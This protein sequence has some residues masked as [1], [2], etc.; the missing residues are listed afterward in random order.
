MHAN[1]PDRFADC[2]SL[3][4]LFRSI[5]QG[6]PNAVAVVDGPVKVTYGQ[7][8]RESDA[9][10]RALGQQGVKP[11]DRVGLVADRTVDS[12][13]AVLGI[14]KAGAAYIPLDPAYPAQRLRHVVR[15]TQV[16][17]IVGRRDHSL[18]VD[19]C[20]LL[21]AR[22]TDLSTEGWNSPPPA[23]LTGFVDSPAYIIHTSGSTGLPKGCAVTHGNVLALLNAALPLFDFSASDRWSLFHSLCFD[24]SVWEL[25]GAFATGGSLVLVPSE[26]AQSP[27]NLVEYL[28]AEEVTVLNIV[29]SVFRYLAGAYRQMNTPPIS[30]RYLIFG[31]ESVNLKE[32]EAFAEN[33]SGCEPAFV[34][35]YGITEIT[36][37][38]T[39]KKIE[40]EDFRGSVRSP[41]GS[42]LPH[43]DIEVRDGSNKVVP[44]GTVGEMWISGGGVAVGYVGRDD[45]TARSFISEE[46]DSTLKRYYRSGDLG[47]YLPNGELEYV[48][49]KDEQVKIL[50]FRIELGEVEAGIRE[51]H[52]AQDAVVT[53]VESRAG[54][55]LLVACVVPAADATG[56]IVKQ[57]KEQAATRL[58]KHMLPSRYVLMDSFP[59]NPSGKID[60]NAVAEVLASRRA[61]RKG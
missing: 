41:I 7:L 6:S 28:A 59:M 60:R 42:P 50:G 48:A 24:F 17:V 46:K 19:D 45:L 23:N 40:A 18:P 8:D 52:A 10:A 53:V 11:G 20:T 13:R 37:H 54:T 26:T 44:S 33:V 22:I 38:A 3:S 61:A 58:P 1:G 55:S 4:E 16:R 31:G 49:R 32:V 15:D 47:R 57:I 12:V 34:N 5:A 56:D 25:W 27:E 51:C 2:S 30:L 29:P 9:L 39:F 36:V 35:M 43:C 21:D 14:I